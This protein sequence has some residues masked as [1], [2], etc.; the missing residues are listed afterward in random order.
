MSVSHHQSAG[1]S[2]Q[3]STAKNADSLGFFEF[4]NTLLAFWEARELRIC[5]LRLHAENECLRLVLRHLASDRLTVPGRSPRSDALQLYLRD[6]TRKISGLRK[7]ADEFSETP[8]ANIAR[9]SVQYIDPTDVPA[10][11]SALKQLD[12][13]KQ[14]FNKIEFYLKTEI[15]IQN[16]IQ[17]L[18]MNNKYN[19]TGGQQGAV[20]DNA[21]VQQIT[22][23]QLVSTMDEQTLAILATELPVLK[24]ELEK[25]VKAPEHQAAA[26]ALGEAE[27]A[28]R[29]KDASKTLSCLGKAG[30]WALEVA[31]T[32]AVPIATKYLESS[33]GLG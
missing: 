3:K 21:S 6:A 2:G 5:L 29:S 33:L 15:N 1:A 17:N 11:L 23:N 31:K 24:A 25:R 9:L 32:I 13:R 22:F 20:G 4:S 7:E 28:A 30:K 16:H 26:I 10:M 18:N 27:T 14:I 8:I 12:V 19:I